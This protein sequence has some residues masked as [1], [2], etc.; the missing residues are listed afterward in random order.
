LKALFHLLIDVPRAAEG[1]MLTIEIPEEETERHL[2]MRAC[3][4]AR[5][6]R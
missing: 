4:C 6:T 2:V 1:A 3:S 5:A